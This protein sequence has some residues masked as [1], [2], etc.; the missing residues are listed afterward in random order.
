MEHNTMSRILVIDVG[1]TNV[2]VGGTQRRTVVKIPSGPTMTAGRMAAAVRKATDGWTYDAVSIGFPGAVKL[3]KPAHEPHNLAG[4]WMRFNYE[5]A[6]R[7]PVK[8]V[9]DAAMQALG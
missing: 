7:A 8:I 6:F 9:N 1:G 5:N 3:G 4:G 2:K